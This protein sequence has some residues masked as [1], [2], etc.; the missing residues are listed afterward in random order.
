MPFGL[1]CGFP[2]N[3]VR[4]CLIEDIVSVKFQVLNPRNPNNLVPDLIYV[5]MVGLIFPLVH[6]LLYHKLILTDVQNKLIVYI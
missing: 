1:G 6:F 4:V 5:V 3:S 2:L